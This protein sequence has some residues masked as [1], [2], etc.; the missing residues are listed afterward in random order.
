[1]KTVMRARL[2]RARSAA[3]KRDWCR[4]DEELQTLLL[5]ATDAEH[6]DLSSALLL[7]A[8]DCEKLKLSEIALWAYRWVVQI[9]PTQAIP[10]LRLAAHNERNGQH[11][12]A[13]EWLKR[14]IEIG[15][16]GK[17]GGSQKLHR[18]FRRLYSETY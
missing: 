15:A 7:L 3:L 12:T 11:Q 4:A 1:M 8:A 9:T 10:Y 17:G 13:L 16:T 18:A 5:Q 2:E 6:K 14:G